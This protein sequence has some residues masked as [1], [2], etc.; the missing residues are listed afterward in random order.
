MN[1]SKKRFV[2]Q[3]L[4]ADPSSESARQ[5]YEQEM[6]ALLEQKLTPGERRGHFVVFVLFGLLGCFFAVS[7]TWNVL[8]GR[9]KQLDFADATF[10]V[11]FSVLTSLALLAVAFI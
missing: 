11:A 9:P 6:S 5:R 4:A 1:E 7:I 3:L 8:K 2:D 10:F